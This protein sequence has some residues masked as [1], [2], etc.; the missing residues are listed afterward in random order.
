MTTNS[1]E[2]TK[3]WR[4]KNIEK[5]RAYRR[6]YEKKYRQ[7]KKRKEYNRIYNKNYVKTHPRIYTTGKLFEAHLRWK[8]DH[9][10]GLRAHA[11]VCYALKTGRM[12]KPNKCQDCNKIGRV[13]AHHD[14]YSKPYDVQW[15]CWS[16]HRLKHNQ[17]L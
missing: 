12:I 7:T 17:T 9:P 11:R 8:Q 3:A 1:S 5:Y 16:C 4:L 13:C 10:N 15:L 14:D 2:Y 6:V